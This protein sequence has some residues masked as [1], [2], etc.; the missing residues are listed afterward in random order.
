M[1]GFDYPFVVLETG[2]RLLAKS[3]TVFNLTSSAGLIRLLAFSGSFGA[4]RPL[5]LVS[6]NDLA[7]VLNYQD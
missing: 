5:T 6:M 3:V 4:E 1:P 2:L 7:L